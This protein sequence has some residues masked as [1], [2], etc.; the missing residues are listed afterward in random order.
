MANRNKLWTSLLF[1]LAMVMLILDSK[2]ATQGAKDGI[3][4]CTQSVIPA[5][6]PFFVISAMVNSAFMGRRFAILSPIGKL[7]GIPEGCESILLLGLIGGYPVG[8]KGIYD[9]HRAGC[10][11][12]KTAKR[13]L[14]FC[15]NAGPSF[16]FGILTPMFSSLA[17][18]WTIWLVQLL[19]ALIVGTILPGKNFNTA[20]LK[21]AEWIPLSKAL[22][23][24]IKTMG[25]VC[26][27]VILF[28]TMI[29]ICQ[30][31]FLFL[32]PVEAQI[33]FSGILELTNGC[34]DL[35]C[36][37]N[38]ALRFQICCCLLS[39]G[40][41]C[42]YMQ[43]KSV[44]NDLGLGMYLPGKVLQTTV[45]FAL[46]GIFSYFLFPHESVRFYLQGLAFVILGCITVM[47][48]CRKNSSRFM[49]KSII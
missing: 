5:L 1:V 49:R 19:S 41:L 32:A 25:N 18:V 14:G 20:Q 2:T 13:M 22:E 10:V 28:R 33:A 21:K 16:I 24:S 36:V 6:L 48:F 4:L 46:S 27:W 38:E 23:L 3:L 9:A 12:T 15:N 37:N 17:I 11:D 47:K 26:G 43:T 35:R 30:K 34:C 40:G 39:F 31:W 8:A 7:C 44:T 29:A 42:V 45:S